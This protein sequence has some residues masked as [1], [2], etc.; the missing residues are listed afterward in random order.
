MATINFKGK[1]IVRNHHLTI[2]YHELVPDAKK[3]LSKK[4]SLNDNLI[5][6]GDNLL[7]LKALLP[8]YAGKVK[9]IYIDPPYNTGNEKWAY[10]D[11][12]NSP[13]MKEWLGKVVDKDDLTRHDKW[14][15]MMLPRLKLLRELLADNGVIF[16]SID[17]VEAHELRQL[18][19]EIF[20]S[21]SF[22]ASFVWKTRQAAGK[23]LAINNVSVEHEYVLAY[24]KSEGVKFKGVMRDRAAF[25]N[26]DNDSRGDWTKYPLDIGSTREE[27]PNCFYDLVD[28]KTGNKYPAN[29]NRVWAFAPETARRLIIGKYIV[30]DPNGKSRPYLKRFWNDFES[31]MKPVSTWMSLSKNGEDLE[32]SGFLDIAY[33]TEGT[34]V[35]NEIF[36][37][38]I[39]DY[40]KPPSLIRELIGQAADKDSIILD[41]FAGSGTTAHA[42]LDS[43]KEDGGNRKFILVEMEDYAD[44]ITAERVRRVIKGVKNAKDDNLKNGLGGTFSYFELGKPIDTERILKG[45]DLPT[46]AEMARYI[47]YTATGEEFTAKK[48]SEKTGFIGE[49]KEYEVYLLYKPD[50]EYLKS[51][52]LTLERAETLGKFTGKKRLVFAPA[53]YLDQEHL[54]RHHIDFAQLPFEIYQKQ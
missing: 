2:P 23:Q 24:Q 4:P 16:V 20:T 50:M 27:R 39:F 18:M 45:K 26:P 32:Y 19:D 22:I 52:A 21:E 48:V 33:N 11:N 54:Q 42:V 1:E 7:A 51:T 35:L 38:K 53:K 34:K 46:F 8:T 3:G 6:H 37:K 9:C 29:P 30:F 49:S 25:K 28:P 41:S 5:I 15:C 36:G 10:N 47:F 31:H 14:L 12:V 13:M 44:K 40:P 17:D 43:N